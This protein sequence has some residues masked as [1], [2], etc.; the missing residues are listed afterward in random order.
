VGALPSGD[1][2]VPPQ[3]PAGVKA[4]EASSSSFCVPAPRYLIL[5]LR[6]RGHAVG[7]RA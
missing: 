4:L 2:A 7:V 6:Q 1:I 3:D 5:G